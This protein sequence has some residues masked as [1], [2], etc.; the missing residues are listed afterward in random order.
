M[1]VSVPKIELKT[2]REYFSRQHVK[3]FINPI[4]YGCNKQKLSHA[5]VTG[6]E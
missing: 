1:S 5:L 2:D 3:N 6:V 4:E